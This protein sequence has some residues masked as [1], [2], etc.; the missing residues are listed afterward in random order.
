VIALAA[1]TASFGLIAASILLGGSAAGFWSGVSALLVIAGT[2]AVTAIS[3]R[4]SDIPTLI[5]GVP[6][7]LAEPAEKPDRLVRLVVELAGR[8]RRDGP[9]AID[10]AIRS[11][12]TPAGLKR[13][14]AMLNDGL[15]AET[16]ER[17]LR[18]EA[19]LTH[20]RQSRLGEL[21]RRAGDVAPAMGLIGT[22]IGLVQMLGSLSTP[23]A[24]GP[25]MAVA[26]L[27]TLYGAILAHVVFMPLSYRADDQAESDYHASL[28]CATGIPALARR[29]HPMQVESQ[30]NALLPS[31]T[32]LI[33]A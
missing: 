24:I 25:A 33:G 18:S 30:L 5:K 23:E 12:T 29:E 4:R 21:G 20:R 9:V 11:T 7:I 26:L 19:E 16:V 13:G 10:N 22:L 27:T 15:S 6:R 14:L 32:A 8:V 2:L 31:T 28:I 17:V 3:A 1:L